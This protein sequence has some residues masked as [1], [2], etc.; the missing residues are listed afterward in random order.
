MQYSR[1]APQ[2][3]HILPKSVLREKGYDESQ[4]NHGANFW[5]LPA[6]KNQNKC[7]MH[8]ADYF[9]DI[10]QKIL[11]LALIDREMFDYRR[12]TTFLESRIDLLLKKVKEKTGLLEKDF[13]PLDK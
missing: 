5:I 7:N 1:N 9:K 13:A 10:N 11:D 4:V 6:G 12:Y 8:P 3:D 2:L